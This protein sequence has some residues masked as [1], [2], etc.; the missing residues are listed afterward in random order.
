VDPELPV[1]ARTIYGSPASLGLAI[2][3][4][5]AG[6]LTGS[7]LFGAVG[8]GWPRRPTFLAIIGMGVL[9]LLVPLSTFFNRFL[10]QIDSRPRGDPK[11]R[12]SP[13]TSRPDHAGS[14][15]VGPDV[16]GSSGQ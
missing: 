13:V 12:C 4:F 7:L 14:C 11:L 16:V 10:R 1:Y 15:T 9:Y 6:A 5:G 3:A 2:G 8:R